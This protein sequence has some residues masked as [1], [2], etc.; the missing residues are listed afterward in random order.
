MTKEL[1]YALR[2]PGLLELGNEDNR[3]RI[4]WR[5]AFARLRDTFSAEAALILKVVGIN[6]GHTI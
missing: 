2:L 5:S 6:I 4:K 3:T 1:L